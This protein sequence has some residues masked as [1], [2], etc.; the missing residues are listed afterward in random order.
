[1]KVKELRIEGFSNSV[2]ST[3]SGKLVMSV[4]GPEGSGKTALIAT[5][6][7]PVAVVC[8][9]RKTRVTIQKRM[10]ELGRE[11]IYLSE[12]DFVRHAKPIELSLMNEKDVT[13]YY[14][15]HVRKIHEACYRALEHKDVN[16]V[17]L[18][19]GSQLWEDTLFKHYGRNQRIMPRDRG[20]ANQDMIDFLNAMTGKHFIITHKMKQ[21]WQNDKPV[22]GKF[23]PNC[24]NGIGH[25]VTA[26]VQMMQNDRYAPGVN[27]P[28]FQ[29]MFGAKVRHC[30]AQP[31]LQVDG[32]DGNFLKDLE[33]SFQM[34]AAYVFPELDQEQFAMV[35]D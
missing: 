7:G 2:H 31:M 34:L 11:D 12:V 20:P 10:Q 14:S 26:V 5:M 8:V 29:W 17:A 1:M 30:Q 25:H 4:F 23:E 3:D 6:P 21:V 13:A 35:A 22:P 33:I 16:S 19:G 15:L 28:D 9:D 24:F 18:D 27:N 32:Q